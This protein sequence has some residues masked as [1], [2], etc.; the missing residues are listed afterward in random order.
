MNSFKKNKEIVKI[1]KNYYKIVN[2][3]I[4]DND[5]MSANIIKIYTDYIFSMELLT[6]R[7]KEKLVIVD[8]IMYKYITDSRFKK[9]MISKLSS[10]KASK[11]ISNIVDYVINKLIEYF[12]DYKDTYTRN[13]YIPRWI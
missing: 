13:I 8:N 10:L 4:Y 9:E 2:S 1:C 7:D 3:E 6:Q 11:G 12:E 5:K